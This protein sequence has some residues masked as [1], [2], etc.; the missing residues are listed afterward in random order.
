LVFLR[1][2][3]QYRIHLVE[4]LA[5]DLVLLLL[6]FA[7]VVFR[8]PLQRFLFAVERALQVGFGVVVQLFALRLEL[9]LEVLNISIQLFQFRLFRLEFLG[10]RLEFA[11]AR[12]A[13]AWWWQPAAWPQPCWSVPAR[14][15]TQP[16]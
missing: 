11:L 10:E 1:V 3:V 12:P 4:N 5:G 14:P 15:R 8:V 6:C 9:L 7:L 2:L 13:R 16:A